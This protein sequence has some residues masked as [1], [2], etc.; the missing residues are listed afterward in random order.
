MAMLWLSVFCVFPHVSEDDQRSLI[1]ARSWSHPPFNFYP[2]AG[3]QHNQ[4]IIIYKSMGKVKDW[5]ISKG[6]CIGKFRFNGI[7]LLL[8][9][10]SQGT[11]S[12]ITR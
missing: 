7:I 2:C 4:G 12:N 11:R 3:V 9:I 10:T 1:L 5:L 8:I 6:K